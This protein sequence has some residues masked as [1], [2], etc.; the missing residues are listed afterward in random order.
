MVL[1]PTP[2]GQREEENSIFNEVAAPPVVVAVLSRYVP[3]NFV[4]PFTGGSLMK[5][6]YNA[7]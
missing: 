4:V 2:T 6:R 7:E 1:R 3:N 5:V